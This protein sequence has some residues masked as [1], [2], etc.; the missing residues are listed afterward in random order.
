MYTTNLPGT[1]LVNKPALAL[2][3]RWQQCPDNAVLQQFTTGANDVASEAI[4]QFVQSN[5][6]IADASFCRLRNVELSWKFPALLLKNIS[7]K[8]C[9]VYMQAQNL[10]T[11]TQYK[12][13][14]PETRSVITL[15]PLR[16]IAAG[17]ELSF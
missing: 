8:N 14:D 12:G 5:G 3:R 7:L 9:R 4:D 1:M 6:T 15:P 2:D 17:I 10:F 13:T 11:I 16:T